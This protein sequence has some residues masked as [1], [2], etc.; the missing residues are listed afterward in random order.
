V[1]ATCPFG[2][3]KLIPR[4]ILREPL[5]SLKRAD[6]FVLSKT[7]IKPVDNET[8]DLLN[9][10]NPQGLIIESIHR[11]LGFS[12]FDRPD[13]ILDT[14][15]LCGKT[16]TLFSGIGDPASFEDLIRSLGIKVGLC[17]RFS[18]HHN[19][20]DKDLDNIFKSSK[21]KN[22]DTIITTQ[23]DA[24]R[25]YELRV[26]SYE[27]R[28]LYLRIELKITKDEERFYHRLLRIYSD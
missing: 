21:D 19:Y 6:I 9:L 17:F 16:V 11:P 1:D 15:A 22:I 24:A 10:I 2:N 8:K 4:G 26:T 13:E 28:V 27:L 18:D 23:K 7:N 3:R 25:L 14:D 12:E 5:T 20:T